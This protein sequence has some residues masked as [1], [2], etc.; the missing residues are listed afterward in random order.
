[1]KTLITLLLTF[2]FMNCLYAQF[3]PDDFEGMWRGTWFNNTFQSTDSAFL[4]V[5]FD[6]GANT[7]E[8]ILD[9]DGGVFGGSD[10]DPITLTGTYGSSGFNA[11]GTSSTY[12]TMFLSGDGA[13]NMTGRMPNVPN[14]GIDSTTLSGT[15]NATNVDLAYIVYFTGG[16]TADGVI[17]LVKEQTSGIE[18][19]SEVVTDNYT[20]HQNYPNP[21]NPSTAIQFSIP[22]EGFVTLNVLNSLGEKVS[23]LVSENLS[24]GTYKYNW[25]ASD[26]PSGIYFYSLRADNFIQTKKLILMK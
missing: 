8:A 5:T 3:N 17:N 2:L 16:G 26:L 4:S 13:G 11:M 12:G 19:E 14:P 1:M 7:L 22:G 9:L 25:N 10:P 23:T 20:L 6:Q 21:F 15:F 24:S 18:K